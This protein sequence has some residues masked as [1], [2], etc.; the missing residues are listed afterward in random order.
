MEG[1]SLPSLLKITVLVPVNP[2]F[3]IDDS[4]T[5]PDFRTLFA[6]GAIVAGSLIYSGL[7][8]YFLDERFHS[9]WVIVGTGKV[10]RRFAI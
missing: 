7:M 10:F 8:P 2:A 6:I 3:Q 1:R 4:E 9:P 5:S